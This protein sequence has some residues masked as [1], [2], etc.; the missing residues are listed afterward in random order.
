MRLDVDLPTTEQ[1]AIDQR[2]RSRE[3]TEVEP[4]QEPSSFK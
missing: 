3:V 1:K 4:R 2:S